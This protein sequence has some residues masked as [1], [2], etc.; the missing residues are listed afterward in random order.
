MEEVFQDAA[1]QRCVVH[2]MRDCAR[3]ASGSRIVA[4]VFRLGDA[5]AAGAAYRLAIEM[6]GS[7][8]GDA[9]RILEEAEPDALPYLDFPA[10]HWKRPRA[11]NVQERANRETRRRSRVVQ[12]FPSVASPERLAG[13]V[14]CDMDEGWQDARYFSKRKMGEPCDESR[15]AGAEKPPTPEGLSEWR[16][17]AK[18]EIDASLEL[19]DEMEAA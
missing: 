7:C 12:V 4:P 18:R 15:A 9:A 1:W 14:T 3:A 16:L 17:V 11:N 8:R 5:G 6:P 2:L 13:A 19:A 10:S